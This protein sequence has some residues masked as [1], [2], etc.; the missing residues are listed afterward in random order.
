MLSEASRWRG[1]SLA[2]ASVIVL[3][4]VTVFAAIAARTILLPTLERTA[5]GRLSSADAA[6]DARIARYAYL[7]DLLAR[8]AEIQAVIAD[9][10][11]ADAANRSLELTAATAGAGALFVLD[12]DGTT[13]AASNWREESSFVGRNYG[14]RPYYRDAVAGR[15]ARYYAVGVTTGVAGY[16][17]SA[18]I[19]HGDAVVGVVVVKI[20]LAPLEE[21]WA[22]FGERIAVVAEDDVVLLSSALADGARQ[23]IPV[24]LACAVV[25]LVIGTMTLTG[26]GTVIGEALIAI[27]KDNLLLTLVLT[28]LFSLLLGMGIPTIPNYII[29]SSLAAPI[30]L[31]IGVPL[32]VSHMFVFYFGIMADLTPPVALAAFAAAP[33]A[34]ESG[35]KVAIQAV[36]IAL[37]GFILPFMAVYN[38]QLML[39]PVAGLEGAAYWSSAAFV[40]MKAV[41][42]VLLWGIAAFGWL[43][44]RASI[45]E[46]ILAVIAAVLLVTPML[47]TDLLGFA[48]GGVVAGLHLIRTRRPVREA[49]AVG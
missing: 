47:A 20:D 45:A 43:V 13:L 34:R 16:F 25:G 41:S 14:F 17:L 37:P 29:T 27:G 26:L 39:Q 21:E 40:L 31:E 1:G 24:G 38:P 23:A 22:R 33:M 49:T 3:V 19:W 10:S 28:M 11:G 2:V 8:S 30:L 36:R 4:A 35:M 7:P 32:I 15:P 6:L 42:A 46:R 48:I 18:P 44:G 12:R 5:D 9:P